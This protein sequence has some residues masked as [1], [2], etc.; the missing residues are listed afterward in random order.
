VTS[1]GTARGG[2]WRHSSGGRGPVPG[3]RSEADRRWTARSGHCLAWRFR[4]AR[5][6]IVAEFLV[7]TDIFVDHLRGARRL[8]P[9]DQVV[10]YSV[11]TRAELYAGRG[12]DEARVGQLLS[13]VRELPVSREVAERAGRLRREHGLPMADARRGHGAR[14][15]PRVGDADRARLPSVASL[16]LVPAKW[17]NRLNQ[18]PAPAGSN[19][20]RP[21]LGSP[22]SP[23][24]RGPEAAL[25]TDSRAPD[26]IDL[27]AKPRRRWRPAAVADRSRQRHSPD[28]SWYLVAMVP[29]GCL[30][31]GV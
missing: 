23:T 19:V 16:V 12:S 21:G 26:K 8:R 3:D 13:P 5:S 4:R 30:G 24:R 17:C 9:G 15:R 22:S 25:P 28:L 29:S 2:H 6:G 7:D 27:D 10:W 1:V 31:S 14:I 11:V 18:D 20:R